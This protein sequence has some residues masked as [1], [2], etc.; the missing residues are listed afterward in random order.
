[1]TDFICLL[2]QGNECANCTDAS[3]FYRD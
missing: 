1:M 3:W 2:M